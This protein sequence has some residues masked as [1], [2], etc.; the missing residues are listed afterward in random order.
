[1]PRS[2]ILGR[3]IRIEDRGRSWIDAIRSWVAIPFIVAVFS[4]IWQAH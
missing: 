2:V 4:E 1:M 3:S